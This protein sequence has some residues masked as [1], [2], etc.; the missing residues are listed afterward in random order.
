METIN[1]NLKE[2]SQDM[3]AFQSFMTNKD[4]R[5]TSEQELDL[6]K[7]SSLVDQMSECR[8]GICAL[9]WAPTKKP[10]I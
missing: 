9:T 3:G 2:L 6:A 7:L 8:K 4:R 1:D 5:L 10:T